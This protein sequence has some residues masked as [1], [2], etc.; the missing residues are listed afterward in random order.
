MAKKLPNILIFAIDSIRRDHMSCYGYTRLTTPHFDRLAA[1][2]TLVENAFSPYIPTTPAYSSMLTG[3]DVISHQMVSLGPKGPLDPNQP[4]LP[5]LLKTAGYTSTVV[6]FD[7]GFFRGF[8]KYLN[9]E[10]W[11]AWEDRP[12]RKAENLNAV[13]LPEMDRL[14]KTG[15]PWM[16]FLRHM[17]PHSPYLP[18]PPF[19][20]MFYSKNPCAKG[21]KSMDPVKAF[22]PFRDF[23]LS[24]MP[25]GI[26]DKDFVIAQYDGELAYMDA[27]CARI[28]THLE[29]LGCAEETLIVITGD[30]G[31]TLY[32]HDI[33]FDHHGLYEPTLVVPLIYYW[34]GKIAPGVRSKAYSF[35]EDMIPT[36]LDLCGLKFLA[37]G[38]KFDGVSLTNYFYKTSESP[39]SEFYITECTW[40]RKHGWRTSI[41]KF[42]DALEPDFHGKPPV[43]LYN[44]IEDP[45]ESVNLA[46]K[47]PAIV[48]ML[49]GRMIAWIAKRCKK[50]GKANPINDYKI[51]LDKYIGSV[52]TAKKLQSR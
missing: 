32:D 39:R 30:H 48:E 18:P 34:P 43:E 40:M 51:G 12:A 50:T 36:I 47:E 6:G 19:D 45:E 20:T 46:E 24:W 1:R 17:D 35:H 33:H 9:F 42:W 31:E 14:H 23:H 37:R 4:T 27:C 5:E 11:L 49:R 26:T 3:Q 28:V 16:L 8:D 44:L 13:T 38:V 15:K 7:E 41:W 29:E 52:A 2:G 10:G 21:N 22:K 25:P